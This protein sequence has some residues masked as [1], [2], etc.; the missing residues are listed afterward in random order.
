MPIDHELMRSLE[1][2]GEY[3]GR[4]TCKDCVNCPISRDYALCEK[5]GVNILPSNNVC[6]AFDAR[7]KNPSEPEFNFD[8]YLEYLGSDFYRPYSIDK[9]IING[10]AKLGEIIIDGGR[11][12]G[13]LPNIYSPWYEYYDKPYCR[14]FMP[15]CHVEYDGNKFEI[16]YRRYRELKTVENVAIKFAIRLWKIKP[17]QRKYNKE[18]NGVYDINEKESI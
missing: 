16:D 6:R 4:Y 12:A 7:I 10:S 17:T 8:D 11:L 1:Y 18:I 2:K 3:G 13:L 5:Q 15:R 14:V 9:E